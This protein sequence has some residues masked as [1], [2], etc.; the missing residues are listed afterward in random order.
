MVNLIRQLGC[1]TLSLV[2]EA[3][4]MQ[5]FLLQA[6]GLFFVPPYRFRNIIKQLQFIGVKSSSIILL[7]GAFTGMVLGLQ[8]YYTLRKY[9]S[10]S[11]LGSAVALSLVR[12]LGPVLTALMVSGRAGS[13][14]T[15]EIG[16]MRI[17]EQL[18]ALDTMAINPM[19]YVVMP[20][21]IAGLM[22]VPLLTAIFDV[23]GIWGG[24]LVGVVL[25]GVSS[26]SYFS[27]MVQS[28][29]SLDVNG[30]IVKSLVFGITI[31]LVA[32]YKGYYTARGAEGVGR[33]TTQTVVLS[34]VLV[35]GWDYILTS[36]FM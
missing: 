21:M 11:A 25:L 27:G 8:G 23:I 4:R 36:F 17:T 14:I 15:A 24:Y 29:E 34:A 1:R 22:A 18:D 13:A 6:L 32:C 3:G 31:M 33:A 12:E 9:G 16:I 7:T 26:G 19:Q 30:G 35:L 10:E 2:Q 20:K 28:V 5:L